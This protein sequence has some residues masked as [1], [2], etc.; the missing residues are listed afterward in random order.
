MSESLDVVFFLLLVAVL[1]LLYELR[2]TLRGNRTRLEELHAKL[3]GLRDELPVLL[4]RESALQFARW[5]AYASLRDRLDLH[6][7]LPYVK[8]W[9]A[10]P[11]FLR[12]I[13]EHC[14][15]HRPA[16]VFE[17]SS[18]L[19]TLILARCCEM[20]GSGQVTSLENGEEYARRTR[21]NLAAY[22]LGDRAEV[23]HAPLV[24]HLVD[25][26]PYQ[27]YATD[28]IAQEGIDM[29]VVDGPPGFLQANSRYPA[30]PVLFERLSERC[31]VFLDDA[32]R[33][34]EKAIVALWRQRFPGL[35]HE[36][37]E[38]ERGCSILRFGPA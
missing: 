30:L 10:A 37:V 36:Y 5:E 29:L 22:G 12:I 1:V 26:D 16:T 9:S 18:G 35:Q 28:G 7:G 31:V 34:D 17:C 25:G 4:E 21:Q 6:R 13:A 2:R 3:D 15:E 11:D 19:T 38:T 33:A 27:W 14:L 32:A 24:E 8:D 20:N 23:I